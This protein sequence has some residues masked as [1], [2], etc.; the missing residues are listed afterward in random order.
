MFRHTALVKTKLSTSTHSFT[1][2]RLMYITT[3]TASQNLSESIGNYRHYCGSVSTNIYNCATIGKN[4]RRI[5]VACIIHMISYHKAMKLKDK[6]I[7]VTFLSYSMKKVM[8]YL[9][10]EVLTQ[11]TIASKTSSK[12]IRPFGFER[13]VSCP[14][15][16]MNRCLT[17]K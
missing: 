14:L 3:D 2:L 5:L 16:C 8:S 7:M 4:T 9:R 17:I 10:F 1:R 6:H 15:N 12:S 13:Q 11:L